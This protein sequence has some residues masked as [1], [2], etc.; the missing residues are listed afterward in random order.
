MKHRDHRGLKDGE[1]EGGGERGEWVGDN[2]V[3]TENVKIK[4][5]KKKGLPHCNS[6]TLS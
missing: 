6:F 2:D 4:E 3:Y 1:V 5:E